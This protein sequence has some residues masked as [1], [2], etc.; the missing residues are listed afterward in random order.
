MSSELQVRKPGDIKAE[1]SRCAIMRKRGRR[2]AAR[3]TTR[4]F[5]PYRHVP[6]G[7][8]SYKGES[9]CKEPRHAPLGLWCRSVMAHPISLGLGTSWPR[10]LPP[11]TFNNP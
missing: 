2:E 9:R 3:H 10:T 7:C 4:D 8:R 6:F 5:D 1:R 11:I